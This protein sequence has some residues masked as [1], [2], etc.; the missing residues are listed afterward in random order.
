MKN[1]DKVIDIVTY[2]NVGAV[3]ISALEVLATILQLF[4]K[5]IMNKDFRVVLLGP[6][7]SLYR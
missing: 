3:Q 6:P 4:C 2:Q 5:T 7:D 1:K